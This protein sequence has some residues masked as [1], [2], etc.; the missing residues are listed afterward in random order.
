MAIELILMLIIPFLGGLIGVGLATKQALAKK[1]S[2]DLILVFSGAFLL[3]IVV[4][5]LLPA[6]YAKDMES[7]GYWILVG[8]FLQS[9]LEYFSRGAEHGHIHSDKKNNFPLLLWVS[10]C[11]HAFIEGFPLVDFPHLAYGMF[12]HKIPI[13]FILFSLLQN[14]TIS[15]A[16]RSLSL[17][18]FLSMTSLGG[19]SMWYFDV[20]QSYSTPLLGIVVGVILHI[21]TTIIFESNE[22]HRFN[23]VKLVCILTAVGMAVIL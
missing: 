10:L 15:S 7:A 1:I 19:L 13:A 17:L 22:G 4:L 6:L 9:F 11:I 18:V 8:I 23:R 12:V 5:E 16:A 2:H 20:I 3:S 14:S 21:A